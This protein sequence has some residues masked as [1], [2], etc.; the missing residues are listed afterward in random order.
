[1]FACLVEVVIVGVIV[2]C[3]ISAKSR[4][5]ADV[6]AICWLVAGVR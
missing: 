2:E 1:M 6:D 4:D 5:T 3:W